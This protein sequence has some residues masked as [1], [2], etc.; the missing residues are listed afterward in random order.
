MPPFSF[1]QY[2]VTKNGNCFAINDEQQLWYYEDDEWTKVSPLAKYMMPLS[3]GVVYYGVQKDDIYK[4][5]SRGMYYADA[6]NTIL[7]AE[8]VD[9]FCADD[10]RVF[11]YDGLQKQVVSFDGENAQAYFDIPEIKDSDK[12]VRHMLANDHWILLFTGAGV[13]QY[14]RKTEDLDFNGMDEFQ[15]VI[16]GLS[17]LYDHKLASFHP[18]SGRLSVFDLVTGEKEYL[19]L[20]DSGE[21]ADAKIS[22]ALHG[23]HVYLS[24]YHFELWGTKAEEYTLKIH[25]ETDEI[26]IIDEKYYENL[27]CTD[28]ALYGGK[29]HRMTKVCEFE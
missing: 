3:D 25:R 21:T 28:T 5:D 1:D 12:P 26:D 16:G 15:D 9:S 11:Y 24:V 8:N 22:C 6:E 23:D 20:Y 4:G 27:L 19:E 13:Y 7:L 14:N 29:I 18:G 2:C 17:V 10:E